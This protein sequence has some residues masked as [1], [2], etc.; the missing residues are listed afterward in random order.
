ML[1][2]TTEAFHEKINTDNEEIILNG[3]P[4]GLQGHISLS[5]AGEDALSVKALKLLHDEKHENVLGNSSSL[6]IGSRLRPG[7]K[8]L[9]MLSHALPPQTPPGTYESKLVIGG[10]ERRVKM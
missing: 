4:S 8:K 9:E 1:K 6:R 7:E 3:P 5:N 2:V 10:A